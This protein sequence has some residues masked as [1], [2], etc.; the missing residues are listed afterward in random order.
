M[1]RVLLFKFAITA[2]LALLILIPLQMVQSIVHERAAYR[3][4]ALQS[5]WSSYAGPQTVAGWRTRRALRKSRG[6]ATTSGIAAALVYELASRMNDLKK[7]RSELRTRRLAFPRSASVDE[8]TR[9]ASHADPRSRR[10]DNVALRRCSRSTWASFRRIP[11]EQPH[12][13]CARLHR[14]LA[15]DVVQHEGA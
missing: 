8:R 10:F 11:A 5:I 1:N 14:Q 6:C 9:W 4:D 2:F 7:L 13:R 15:R 3:R 12:G